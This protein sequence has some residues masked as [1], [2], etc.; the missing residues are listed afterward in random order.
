V[1]LCAKYKGGETETARVYRVWHTAR[2]Y[3]AST[4]RTLLTLDP[5]VAQIPGNIMH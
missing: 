4:V 2:C 3:N 1:R 5:D